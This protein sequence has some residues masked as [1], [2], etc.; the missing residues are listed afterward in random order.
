MTNAT[1]RWNDERVC[2][3][4][5]TIV[6]PKGKTVVLT[7]SVGAGKSSVLA[8]LTNQMLLDSGTVSL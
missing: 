5:V 2:L 3:D 8:A 7:G 6:V 4:N 1:L